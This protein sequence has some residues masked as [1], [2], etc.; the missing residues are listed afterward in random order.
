[1][2]LR[3]LTATVGI[4]ILVG[5]IWLGAPWLTIVVVVAGAVGI[6]EFYRLLPPRVAPLPIA[7]GIELLDVGANY[8]CKRCVPHLMAVSS[9]ATIPI[10]IL[11]FFAQKTFIE[12][13]NL[14][15][16]KG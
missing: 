15:G 7:L 9:L 2:R 8:T 12:G 1:M 16:T 10:I 4:P 11:F 6:W 13:I 3:L 5:A 14:T